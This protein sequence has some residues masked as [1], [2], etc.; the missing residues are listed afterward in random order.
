[1][2][3]DVALLLRASA[4]Q[5][6]AFLVG[7]KRLDLFRGDGLEDTGL[8]G[9][10]RDG[11]RETDRVLLGDTGRGEA[12]DRQAGLRGPAGQPREIGALEGGRIRLLFTGKRDDQ[13]AQA[14]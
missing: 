4:E 11:L 12:H 7:E 1:S 3:L 14:E 10:G 9:V 8:G 13:R 6:F 5:L 2:D